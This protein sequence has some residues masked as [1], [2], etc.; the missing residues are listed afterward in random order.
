VAQEILMTDNYPKTL[1]VATSVGRDAWSTP[2][3]P[4][5]KGPQGVPIG[6]GR[7]PEGGWY[8]EEK[9]NRLDALKM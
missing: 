3:R 9:V 8:S 4:S 5:A 1:N 2:K 6:S 7:K